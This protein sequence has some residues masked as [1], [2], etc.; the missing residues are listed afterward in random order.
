MQGR[1]RSTKGG[2]KRDEV[3][4]FSL[5]HLSSRRSGAV[6]HVFAC[7]ESVRD[8][9]VATDSLHSQPARDAT[10]TFSRI[11]LECLLT[12]LSQQKQKI[13]RVRSH[14]ARDSSRQVSPESAD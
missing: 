14:L 6:S 12:G 11:P 7:S 1:V 3:E 4:F 9:G 13:I 2:H 5:M 10:F 8:K